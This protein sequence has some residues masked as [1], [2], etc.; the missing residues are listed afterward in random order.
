MA[1]GFS[2]PIA[3]PAVADAVAK[4]ATRNMVIRDRFPVTGAT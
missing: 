2:M 1:L 4:G 3:W